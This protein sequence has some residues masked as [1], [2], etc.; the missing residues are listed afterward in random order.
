M[1]QSP[2]EGSS[3]SANQEISYVLW[4][5]EIYNH[6]H[7]SMLTVPTLSQINAVL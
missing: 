4:N 2:Y 6:I 7:K 5:Q 3:S 1:G